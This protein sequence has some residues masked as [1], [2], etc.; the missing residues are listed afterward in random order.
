M[1]TLL[2]ATGCRPQAFALLERMMMRQT[3][4]GPVRWLIVDDGE[5]A[6]PVTFKRDGWELE[7]LRPQPYW[8][9][10]QNTQARNLLVGLNH[11]DSED[12]LLVI[13]D[14]DH[15]AADWLQTC[16]DHLDRASLVGERRAK[17]YNVSQRV[18]RQLGNMGHASLCSTAMRGGAIAAFRQSCQVNPKFIDLHLWRSYADRFLFD[19]SSVVGIKGMPGRGGI[20][21]G[22]QKGFN[23][24]RDLNGLLLRQWIG[25]D[26]DWYT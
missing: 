17:Y 20:G 8:K 1:L 6:Q 18:G 24:Q 2:T 21:M 22:H 11:V 16:H 26:A 25:P 9:A 7:V 5:E 14:D 12:R 4:A 19:G 15:Y 23:G 10:G 13:E 3:Y